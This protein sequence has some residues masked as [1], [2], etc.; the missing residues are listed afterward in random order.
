M[1]VDKGT[2]NFAKFRKDRSNIKLELIAYQLNKQRRRKIQYPDFGSLVAH[3]SEKT[4]IHRTTLNRNSVY[5]S[6][7]LQ[8]LATQ[9]GASSHVR[10]SDAT[11]ELLKAK[12]YDSRLE[13]RNQKNQIDILSKRLAKLYEE[14]N[15]DLGSIT[16]KKQNVQDWYLAFIDTAMLLKLLID[17]LNVHGE[18]I[19]IDTD[20]KQLIDLS[21][22]SKDR[23]IASSERVR[24]FIEFYQKLTAQEKPTATSSML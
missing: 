24:W 14:S 19:Q 23:V 5:K 10:D 1:G 18:T 13:I 22:P 11:P 6:S 3:V 21:A 15:N 17:R 20:K 16:V 2:D 8:Y 7:L 9:P 4:G 12:L